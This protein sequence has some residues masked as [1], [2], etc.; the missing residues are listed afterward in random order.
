MSKQLDHVTKTQQKAE[1]IQQDDDD[2][3]DDDRSQ[4]SKAPQRKQVIWIE[5]KYED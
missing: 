5:I 2:S 4:G 1:S 3:R